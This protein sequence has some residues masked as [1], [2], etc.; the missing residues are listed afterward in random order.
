MIQSYSSCVSSENEGKTRKESEN[1]SY[2][3]HKTFQQIVPPKDSPSEDTSSSESVVLPRALVKPSSQPFEV[4][5]VSSPKD[6]HQTIIPSDCDDSFW[7]DDLN[8]GLCE[9]NDSV[10][11]QCDGGGNSSSEGVGV[12]VGVGKGKGEVDKSRLSSENAEVSSVSADI[13]DDDLFSESVILSTQ[14]VEEAMTTKD[15]NYSSANHSKDQQHEGNNRNINSAKNN[16]RNNNRS[17][18]NKL[19]TSI[20]NTNT[21]ILSKVNT[22]QRNSSSDSPPRRQVRRSF[23]FGPSP[24]DR[25]KSGSSNS[26][27][28][29][30]QRHITTKPTNNELKK[31]N[32]TPVFNTEKPS[33]IQKTSVTNSLHNRLST[34][35]SESHNVRVQATNF[36]SARKPLFKSTDTKAEDMRNRNNNAQGSRG[37]LLRSQS[38]GNARLATS[39]PMAR[40]SNSS[41]ELDSCEDLEDD[42][43]FKSLLSMLPEEE[44]GISHNSSIS[45]SPITIENKSRGSHARGKSLGN[46]ILAVEKNVY[47]IRGRN[48]NERET[49]YAS[50]GNG[51]NGSVRTLLV[52]QVNQPPGGMS[53]RGKYSGQTPTPN[54]QRGRPS[55]VNYS[56][57]KTKLLGK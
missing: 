35:S 42:E 9:I 40:R 45:L 44:G 39:S 30:N 10:L 8:L 16:T 28:P 12:G 25:A 37:P 55:V 50:R 23:R 4:L 19:P 54:V 36:P 3:L 53:A 22:N 43:F 49:S 20:L 46:A 17:E 38:I 7:G 15:T 34:T 41:V 26:A 52:G 2:S 13:F 48:N 11:A 33:N 27:P 18:L 14:A 56:V 32:L 29:Q 47:E 5:G 24:T 31:T 57:P 6:C 51:N 1:N 21:R